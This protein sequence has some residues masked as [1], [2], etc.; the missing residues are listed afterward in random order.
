MTSSLA[1]TNENYPFY[2]VMEGQSG[3]KVKTTETSAKAKELAGL[4]GQV[5]DQI[6]R[7]FQVS[8]SLTP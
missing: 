3:N 5:G 4:H 2:L 7:D 6:Y 1:R 8:V